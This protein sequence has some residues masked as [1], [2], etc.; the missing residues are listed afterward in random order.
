[1]TTTFRKTVYFLPFTIQNCCSSILRNASS[2]RWKYS[3][4]TFS[5]AYPAHAGVYISLPWYI[6]FIVRSWLQ[7]RWSAILGPS[8]VTTVP[9]CDVLAAS[10]VKGTIQGSLSVTVSQH[11]SQ[12]YIDFTYRFTARVNKPLS[13]SP[14][15]QTLPS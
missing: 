15:H 8:T 12:N 4:S 10:P 7:R 11:A 5:V 13:E 6:V 2:K 9:L 1:M 14:Q 3:M